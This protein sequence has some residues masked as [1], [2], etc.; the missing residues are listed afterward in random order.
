MQEFQGLVFQ[1]WEFEKQAINNLSE[2][3]RSQLSIEKP[4]PGE[5]QTFVQREAFKIKGYQVVR[6]Q[7]TKKLLRANRIA[8][9]LE[10]PILFKFHPNP[11]PALVGIAPVMR[12][13]CFDAIIRDNSYQGVTQ[14]FI[15]DAL[16]QTIGDCESQVEKEFWHL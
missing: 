16:N 3:R 8:E 7:I 12:T 10:V 11:M 2:A 5:F 9:N 1:L 4:M 13:S 14:H 15:Y 6:D